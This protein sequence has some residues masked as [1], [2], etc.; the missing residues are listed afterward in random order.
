MAPP[1]LLLANAAVL[2][3]PGARLEFTFGLPLQ[4]NEKERERVGYVL[5]NTEDDSIV[6]CIQNLTHRKPAIHT[7]KNKIYDGEESFLFFSDRQ[8]RQTGGTAVC[9]LTGARSSMLTVMF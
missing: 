8:P 4:E 9:T 1:T 6:F 3:P 2:N 5:G 7:Q